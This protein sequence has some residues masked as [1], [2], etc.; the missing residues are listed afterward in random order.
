MPAILA[1]EAKR[2]FGSVLDRVAAGETYTIMRR[3][4]PVARIVPVDFPQAGSQFGALS[5]FADPG[6]RSKEAG[7]FAK[8]METKHADR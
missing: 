3:N 1:T 6:R 2:S 7:A 8:A 4:K 5:E